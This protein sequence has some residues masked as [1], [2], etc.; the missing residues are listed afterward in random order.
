VTRVRAWTGVA[1]L[2]A[3]FVVGAAFG[4]AAL[5]QPVRAISYLILAV[6]GGYATIRLA[7]MAR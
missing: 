7:R 5:G 6:C 3:A 2:P 1:L 4:S